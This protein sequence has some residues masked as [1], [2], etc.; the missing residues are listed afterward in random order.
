VVT[1]SVKEVFEAL[2]K[3]C[4]NAEPGGTV[5]LPTKR[6]STASAWRVSVS[7]AFSSKAIELLRWGM[8]AGL[9]SNQ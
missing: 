9:I 8:R 6:Q 1:R 4:A 7:R 5:L 3:Q 2:E